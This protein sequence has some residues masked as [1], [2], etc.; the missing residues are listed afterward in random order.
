MVGLVGVVVV[1]DGVALSWSNNS[2]GADVG[3]LASGLMQ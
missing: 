2:V 3:A 1:G